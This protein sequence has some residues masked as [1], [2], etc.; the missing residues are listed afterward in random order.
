MDSILQEIKGCIDS[1]NWYAA[2]T[3]TMVL[4][5]I[6][7]TLEQPVNARKDGNRSRYLSWCKKHLADVTGLNPELFYELRCGVV[8]TGAIKHSKFERVALSIPGQNTLHN[9]I[10][11]S[12]GALTLYL[13]AEI[14]VGEVCARVQKWWLENRDS[15]LI[16]ERSP[17]VISR[18][19]FEGGP[20][21]TVVAFLSDLR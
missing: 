3:L 6:C 9:I 14:L 21:G 5:D 1:G 13:D 20:F 12:D 19:V 17:R 11:H 2:V 7:A 18:G 4:P 15:E 16:R 8:H 10:I